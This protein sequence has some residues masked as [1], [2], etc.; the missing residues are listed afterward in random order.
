MW[1]VKNESIR[2]LNYFILLIFLKIKNI[3]GGNKISQ[4]QTY[5]D[6]KIL[7]LYWIFSS[8]SLKIYYLPNSDHC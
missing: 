4:I 8:N 3:I 5:S 6:I 7:M 2:I 1:K